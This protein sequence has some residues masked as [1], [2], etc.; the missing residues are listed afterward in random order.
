MW[1]GIRYQRHGFSAG[2]REEKKPPGAM[3]LLQL[4]DK[5]CSSLRRGERE[6]KREKGEKTEGRRRGT[7]G[8]NV[9]SC[10]PFLPSTSTSS[11][12]DEKA[13]SSSPSGFYT[14]VVSLYCL[15]C[16]VIRRVSLRD[17]PI[18][19]SPFFSSTF[20]LCLVLSITNTLAFPICAPLADATEI[21]G[22][23]MISSKVFL[24]DGRIIYIEDL[25]T[26][27]HLH[28]EYFFL[29]KALAHFYRRAYSFEDQNLYDFYFPI[30]I[31]RI[32][33]TLDLYIGISSI[34]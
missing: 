9:T 25:L 18:F 5:I 13:L 34:S 21:V 32:L 20:S 4:R 23:E 11:R 8:F 14:L 2:V 7:R 10:I 3:A 31:A 16:L 27:H 6:R 26:I 15:S 22:F 19:F 12:P 29:Q 24:Q 33:Y 28:L 17:A 1:Y 30:F